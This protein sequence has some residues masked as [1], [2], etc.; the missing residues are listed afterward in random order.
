MAD[1]DFLGVLDVIKNGTNPEIWHVRNGTHPGIGWNIKT[2][3]PKSQFCT[4]D[5]KY[6]ILSWLKLCVDFVMT[7]TWTDAAYDWNGNLLP[8]WQTIWVKDGFDVVPKDPA[9]TGINSLKLI[10]STNGVEPAIES[11]IDNL[12]DQLVQ[13]NNK[14][15]IDELT[16]LLDI[17]ET[18][19]LQT[20]E[21]DIIARRKNIKVIDE[22]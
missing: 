19:L 22:D 15:D 18:M 20:S 17:A 6:I 7:V 14:A 8:E 5:N 13:S 3:I 2:V 1:W 9:I 12:R 10:T 11:V 21:S 4:D 16:E